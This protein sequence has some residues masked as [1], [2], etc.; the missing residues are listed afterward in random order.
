MKQLFNRFKN[1]LCKRQ[2]AEDSSTTFATDVPDAVGHLRQACM[3]R[4]NYLIEEMDRRIG[5]ADAEQVKAVFLRKGVTTTGNIA[6]VYSKSP[7]SHRL[8][9]R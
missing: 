6:C 4:R 9:G 5:A 1:L 7:F 3:Q 8:E 2:S